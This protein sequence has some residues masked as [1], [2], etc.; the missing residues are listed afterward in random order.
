MSAIKTYFLST[1]A[2]IFC[3]T[4]LS[5]C[6]SYHAPR[7]W[8]PDRKK[9]AQDAYGGW[10][11]L[12]WKGYLQEEEVTQGEFVGIYDTTAFVLDNTVLIHVPMDRITYAS[13]KI[14]DDDRGLF[15]IWT[16]L[17]AT[18]TITNGFYLAITAPFWIIAGNIITINESESGLFRTEY[19]GNGWWRTVAKYSR[20]PQGIP[21]GVDLRKL[22]S[23]IFFPD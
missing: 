8:L 15:A 9:V 18:S 6:A 5:S 3:L 1:L 11:Y 14:N 20:F 12:E 4:L 23:K 21:K 22:I 7:G 2:I 16:L 19:P 13:L 10:I 17:G